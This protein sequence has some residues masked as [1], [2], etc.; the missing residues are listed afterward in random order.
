MLFISNIKSCVDGEYVLFI[1]VDST[2][3][4]QAWKK[5]TKRP[6]DT[7]F[8]W[9]HTETQHSVVKKLLCKRVEVGFVRLSSFVCVCVCV[10]VSV[11]THFIFWISRSICTE[12]PMNICHWMTHQ[13][14]SCQFSAISNKIEDVLIFKVAAILA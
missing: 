6:T 4:C 11:F 12:L 2:T 14:S 3:G 5:K 10:L 9:R 8:E 7:V 1:K 13:C